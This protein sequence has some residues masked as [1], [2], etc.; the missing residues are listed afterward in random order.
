MLKAGNSWMLTVQQSIIIWPAGLTR[1]TLLKTIFASLRW[2]ETSFFV[3][4]ATEH[5]PAMHHCDS[6]TIPVWTFDSINKENSSYFKIFV[7]GSYLFLLQPSPA[8][9]WMIIPQHQAQENHLQSCLQKYHFKGKQSTPEK[10]I[11]RSILFVEKS[12]EMELCNF[13]TTKLIFNNIIYRAVFKSI[14]R[15]ILSITSL[16]TGAS[17][18]EL[19]SDIIQQQS[20]SSAG[21]EDLF[22][23][24]DC[25]RE[26]YWKNQFCPCYSC[27]LC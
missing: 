26:D 12:S 9:R 7:F 17:S 2:S 24:C 4:C 14:L 3:L 19:Y 8:K 22:D 5:T 18:A 16:F 21:S 27:I 25:F 23:N 11:P 10:I 15:S 13:T 6:Q 1:I 20:P